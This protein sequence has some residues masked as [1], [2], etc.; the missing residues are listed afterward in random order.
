MSHE[1]IEPGRGVVY[2]LPWRFSDVLRTREFTKFFSEYSGQCFSMRTLD[3][4]SWSSSSARTPQFV[5]TF[6][7]RG[8]LD[9]VIEDASEA[10]L[11]RLFLEGKVEL[12]GNIF[13]LLSVARYTLQ[14]S[15]G[16]SGGLVRTI[17]RLTHDFS[18]K[19]NP[20][21]RGPATKNWHYS[22][23]PL[24]LPASFFE[25]WLGSILTHSCSCFAS[26]NDDEFESAQRNAL[27][28]SCAWLELA[29]GDGL[30]DIGCGWGS[31]LVHA[32]GEHRVRAQGVASSGSQ[33]TT[34]SRRI[35]LFGL[36]GECSV[37]DRDLR[38]QPYGC[39]DFGK[40]ADVGIFEQVARSDLAEYLRY[41]KGL[42]APEGLLL[43]HRMTASA[44]T[45]ACITSLPPEF[46]FDGIS[47]ELQ[48]AEQAGF[49]VLR[50]E[51]LSREYV[52]TV[53]IWTDRLL[54]ARQSAATQALSS[55]YR[56]WLLY[57]IEVAASLT[58]GEAQVHRVLLRRRAQARRSN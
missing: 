49:D 25:P 17:M 58:A 27:E 18:R 47:R 42:L 15:E 57:L 31:L 9:A 1:S 11:S 22:P 50:V 3:G 33:A 7:T 23:C 37:E 13:V 56:A 54:K 44:E 28:R 5:V 45:A 43:L 52:Q 32:A 35:H 2:T 8:A 16:L 48:L 40:V 24:E 38:R 20:A 51:S 30:L 34:A 53:R 10:T 19:I 41:I 55:A 29:P 4:W 14:N 21:Y 36:D 26:D 6:E 39:G 46:F 12:D